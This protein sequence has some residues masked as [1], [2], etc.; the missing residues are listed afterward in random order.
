[1]R[2]SCY[3]PLSLVAASLPQPSQRA[4]AR[5]SCAA[6]RRTARASARSCVL[7]TVSPARRPELL[8][9]GIVPGCARYSLE[10]V[11]PTIDFTLAARTTVSS[12][13]S[14]LPAHY[15]AHTRLTK[16]RGDH[17]PFV[18]AISGFR[19]SSTFIAL[20]PICLL[21]HQSTNP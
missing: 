10:R 18:S 17:I 2:E 6:P 11:A 13:M 7:C 1:V 20:S 8:R 16:S 15:R 14:L 3:R 4:L 5:P 19:S 21:H 12:I 9:G